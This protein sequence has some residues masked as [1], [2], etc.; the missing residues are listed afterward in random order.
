MRWLLSKFFAFYFILLP[1]SSISRVILHVTIIFPFRK[2]SFNFLTFQFHLTLLHFLLSTRKNS[3]CMKTRVENVV[4]QHIRSLKAIFPTLIQ[5]KQKRC[6]KRRNWWQF[7]AAVHS[8][9]RKLHIIHFRFSLCASAFIHDSEK[10]RKGEKKVKM[11]QQR[12]IARKARN[13]F[14][15]EEIALNLFPCHKFFVFLS[16]LNFPSSRCCSERERERWV[17]RRR[18]LTDDGNNFGEGIK[19]SKVYLKTFE[20]YCHNC[21]SLPCF[22]ILIAFVSHSSRSNWRQRAFSINV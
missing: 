1:S 11:T 14:D 17:W 10:G 12:K 8:L 6:K 19:C 7:V 16:I 18:N 5:F 21:W 22:D 4:H 2:T 20:F 13:N 15:D 3:I 9:C